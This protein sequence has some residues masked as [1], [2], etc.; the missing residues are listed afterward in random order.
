MLF[1]LLDVPEV[2]NLFNQGEIEEIKKMAMFSLLHY[3]PWMLKAKYAARLAETLHKY[4]KHV[5]ILFPV[6]HPIC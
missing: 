3:L 5:Y 2:A 1:L 4:S 6:H